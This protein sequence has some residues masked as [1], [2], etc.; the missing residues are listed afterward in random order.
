MIQNRLLWITIFLL[1]TLFLFC[2]VYLI[3]LA[4]VIAT[5]FTE[6]NGFS[7][8]KFAGFSNYISLTKDEQFL[9]ALRNSIL[10]GLIA[11][12]VHVPFGVSVALLLNRRPVG[13][14][15]VRAV[16]LLP[17][18]IPP[19][20]LALLYVFLFN[21][22]IGLLNEVLQFV[23]ITDSEIYWFY[24]PKYAFVS[25]TLVWVFYAG[26][27]IL[28]TMAELASIP[29]ELRESALIDGATERQVEWYIYL[30]L[31]KNIIGVGVIISVT[32]VFKMFEYVYFTTGGGPNHET[33]SLGLMIY[34]QATLRYQYGY[35]NAI[36]VV[37]LILGLSTIFI[38]TRAFKMNKERN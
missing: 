15:F 25:V 14:R 23:G 31:L 16:S 13:W 38:V 8:I 35:S 24:D 9:K 19:A 27:I 17:N 7:Q 36:G 1:P 29:P 11:A 30:P 3:P 18:L 20:A 32:E 2:L 28:I 10:W 26:V 12:G 22:G 33:M 37:L 34:K 21:P 6:W 5:S 4:T